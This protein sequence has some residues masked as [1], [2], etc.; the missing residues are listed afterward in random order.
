MYN[1]QTEQ[2]VKESCEKYFAHFD[3]PRIEGTSNIMMS[4]AKCSCGRPLGG[5]IGSFTWGIV[6]GEGF[7]SNCKRPARAVHRIPD[8]RDG[9][10]IAT[11]SPVILLY[12]LEPT[13]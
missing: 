5:F 13:E 2:W 11:L 10:V 4:A 12:R 7:C 8:H 9:E 6:H 1:D 3:A